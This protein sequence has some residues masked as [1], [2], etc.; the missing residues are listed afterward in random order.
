MVAALR[1][2]KLASRH[3]LPGD[4]VFC[5]ETG[6]PLHYPNLVR[7]GLDKA[8]DAARI[9]PPKPAKGEKLAPGSPPR[10]RWHDLRHTCA[11]L[12]VSEKCDPV[13]VARVLGHA[14]PGFTLSCYSHLFDAERHAE[15]V[16]ASLEASYAGVL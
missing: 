12:H 9:N 8:A 4:F 14:S 5:S 3:S 15:R 13:Y 1:E 11:S 10:V 6:G 7:R 2:W 16:S